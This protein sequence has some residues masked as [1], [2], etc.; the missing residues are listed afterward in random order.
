MK[1]LYQ[2]KALLRQQF[3]AATYT[4]PAT[5]YVALSTTADGGIFTEPSGGGYQR[6]AITNNTASFSYSSDAAEVAT[7]V[8]VNFS[9]ATGD[10]GTVR[11]CGLFDAATGGNLC[12]SANLSVEKSVTQGSTIMFPAGSIVFTES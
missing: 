7:S 11:S 6:V 10:W 4:P 5:W 8:A 3:G 2:S 1:S 12:W 9:T